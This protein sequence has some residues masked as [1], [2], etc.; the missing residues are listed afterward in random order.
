VHVRVLTLNVQGN[1]G[2]PPRLGVLNR[3]LRRLDPDLVALQEVLHTPDRKQLQELLDGTG[4]VG[5]HQ[6]QAMGYEPPWADRYGGNAVATRWPHRVLEVLDLRSVDAPDVPWCSLAVSV[7]SP[8]DNDILF[9]ATTT[10][11]RVDAKGPGAPGRRPQ[12]SR[13]PAPWDPSHHHGGRL[14][15]HPRRSQHPL[16]HRPAIPRRS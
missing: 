13:C 12:R 16:P 5:T 8:T 3:E 7:A 11:W 9:L 2:D 1:E 15:R 4:L 14:Q 6:A 10:A